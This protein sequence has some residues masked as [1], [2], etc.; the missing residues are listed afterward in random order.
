MLNYVEL[1]HAHGVSLVFGSGTIYGSL[2][3]VPKNGSNNWVG[4][5]GHKLGEALGFP[6]KYVGNH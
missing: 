6:L 5:W 1:P 3:G 2:G 4:S